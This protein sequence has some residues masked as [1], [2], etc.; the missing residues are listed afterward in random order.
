MTLVKIAVLA[1]VS[2]SSSPVRTN[3]TGGACRYPKEVHEDTLRRRHVG[4]H[5]NADGRVIAHGR[6]QAAG[7]LLFAD[8]AVAM[9][10]AITRRQRVHV[11][12]VQ[13]PYHDL[14]GMTHERVKER[15]DLPSAEVAGKQQYTLAALL[16]GLE[17][18]EALIDRQLRGIGLD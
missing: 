16:S 3:S 11:R 1:T 17:I 12:I 10:I 7:E 8:H 5:E 13:R 6:D 9:Q 4:V 15:A 2:A 18:L 14:H